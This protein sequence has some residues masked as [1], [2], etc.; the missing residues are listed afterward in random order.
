[1]PDGSGH[2]LVLDTGNNRVQEFDR[3]WNPVRV[4]GS[5]GSG[6]GEFASP[7]AMAMDGNGDILIADTGNDRIQRFTHDGQYLLSWGTHGSGVGQ[8]ISPSGV[9]VD[10]FGYVY[11]SDSGNS[12]IQKFDLSGNYLGSWGSH[13]SGPWQFDNPTAI[14]TD[15]N[16]YGVVYVA[17]P[18]NHRVSVFAYQP[19]PTP[20]PTLTTRVQPGDITS[21]ATVTASSG[22]PAP[23]VDGNVTT[24]WVGGAGD[25]VDLGYPT[26]VSI[27]TVKLL[28]HG[29]SGSGS[30]GFGVWYQTGSGD[31]SR[32]VYAGGSSSPLEGEE[33]VIQINSDQVTHIRLVNDS[34]TTPRGW[35]EVWLYGWLPWVIPTNTP[36]NTPTPT[37]TPTNTPTPTYTPTNTPTPTFTP[38]PTY[39]PTN[40]PTPTPTP[41]ETPLATTT[42]AAFLS[43]DFSSTP[44]RSSWMPSLSNLTY[45]LQN[46]DLSLTNINLSSRFGGKV[47]TTCHTIGDFDVQVDYSVLRWATSMHLA[48]AALAIDGSNWFQI[49]RS[50]IWGGVYVANI[51][52]ATPSVNT[53]DMTGTFRITRIGNVVTVYYN[54]SGIWKALASSTQGSTSY[55]LELM[56]WADV[57]SSYGTGVFDN[58]QVNSGLVECPETA[59]YDPHRGNNI[60]ADG[61]PTAGTVNPSYPPTAA[62][63]NN[64]ATYTVIPTN[65]W[66]MLSFA[67]PRLIR[68]VDIGLAYKGSGEIYR[69]W[70]D[71]GDGTYKLAYTYTGSVNNMQTIAA[72]FQTPQLIK[73]LKIEVASSQPSAN[74]GEIRVFEYLP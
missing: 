71:S 9:A 55:Y 26:P 24:Y 42:A 20:T 30:G 8:F 64:I 17:D 13:G 73:N 25:W 36:T 57:I 15:P 23:A 28:W 19:I 48:L 61:T 35:W 45:S 54:Q 34:S 11:V 49:E 5:A 4:W 22:D 32:W 31:G 16:G 69:F 65:S 1:V 59:L 3:D 56:V 68:A 52:G 40:T 43:D 2:V 39:T 47:Y 21:Y 53:S 27:S 67:Q 18:G 72:W 51:D 50:N 12:R 70:V 60:A 58:F 7:M 38:T 14:T 44:L 37:Y 29:G 6:N 63:D 33:Y 10:R 41:T 66:W 46:A 74:V 62:I